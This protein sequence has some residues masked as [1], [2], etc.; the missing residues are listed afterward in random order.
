MTGGPRGLVQVYQAKPEML[1][2][3]SIRGWTAIGGI[4]LFLNLD[5]FFAPPCPG[6]L[7]RQDSSTRAITLLFLNC[8][9][10]RRPSRI[11]T[12]LCGVWE[13][14]GFLGGMQCLGRGNHDF[15]EKRRLLR[16]LGNLP[17]VLVRRALLDLQ[18]LSSRLEMF[19]VRSPALDAAELL[20]PS[21]QNK[22]LVNNIHDD[23]L[24]SRFASAELDAS[25]S[26]LYAGHYYFLPLRTRDA[27]PER[28]L[29]LA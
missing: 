16:L 11:G 29:R 24:S 2:E 14:A 12:E 4:C 20:G 13:K 6:R 27:R 23:A 8:P 28:N 19:H 10:S 1:V 21:D 15:F 3:R 17:H 18:A 22:V 9:W 25:S 26:D 7:N 5:E